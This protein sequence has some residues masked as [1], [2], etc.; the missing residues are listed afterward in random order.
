MIFLSATTPNT[1]EFSDWI[2]RTKRKPVHV[3]KT[4]YRPVPLSFHLW[5]GNKL[6]KI[7]EGKSGFLGSGYRDAE[8]ALLPA[9]A[10]D[11]KKKG[12]PRATSKPMGAKNLMWQAQGGKNQW[13]SLVRFLDR[14]QLTPT[15]VFSFSK[16]KCEEIARMLQSLDLNTAKERSAVQGFVIQA[17]SRLSQKD[18]SLPQV[19]MVSEMVQRGIGVHHGGLLPILK[20]CVEILFSRNLIK[21][22][23]ATEVSYIPSLIRVISKRSFFQE[24][25]PL[26]QI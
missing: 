17:V 16:K 18:A 8:N 4:N 26:I 5:A 24:H 15:V 11:P 7:M 20:E 12:D 6:H 10:K 19:L 21:V 1:L 9:S 22:L 3:V 23:F 25:S 14:E 13:M 2:G